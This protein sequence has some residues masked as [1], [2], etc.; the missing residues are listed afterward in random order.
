MRKENNEIISEKAWTRISDIGGISLG[1]PIDS[2]LVDIQ[3]RTMNVAEHN[4]NGLDNAPKYNEWVYSRVKPYLHGN[5]LEIGSGIGTYSRRLL[6]DFGKHRVLFSDVMPR[7]AGCQSLDVS[8]VCE[9]QNW[10]RFDSILGLNVLEHV[11]HSALSLLYDHLNLGGHLIV[12]VPAHEFLFNI[13]DNKVGHYRRYTKAGLIKDM[14]QAEY[15]VKHV[16]YFN[17]LAILGWYVHGNILGIPKISEVSAKIFNVLTPILEFVENNILRN[18][19]GI[20][21]IG[22]FEK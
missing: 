2:F 7:F 21:L 5:I 18:C 3:R 20:S 10:E 14:T 1:L 16:S 6:R 19:I 17:V 12:Q 4:L 15:K 13:I 22:V 8:D 9:W 11:D